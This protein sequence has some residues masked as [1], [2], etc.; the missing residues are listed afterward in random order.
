MTSL[1][2][3][4]IIKELKKQYPQFKKRHF[5]FAFIYILDENH[6]SYFDDSERYRVTKNGKIIN[7]YSEKMMNEII[8]HI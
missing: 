8:S 4:D 3:K 5:D 2:S 1:K 6:F 7:L